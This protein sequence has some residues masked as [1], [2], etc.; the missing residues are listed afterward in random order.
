MQTLTCNCRAWSEC[1]A[2][3]QV[4]FGLCRVALEDLFGELS[5]N[6]IM[7]DAIKCLVVVIVASFIFKRNVKIVP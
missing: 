3:L 1:N 4:E 2:L 7:M 5:K 6:A